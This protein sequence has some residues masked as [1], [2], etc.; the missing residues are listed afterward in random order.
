MPYFKRTWDEPRGDVHND[1]GTS[2]WYFETAADLWPT[3]QMEVYA[4]GTVL[5]YDTA[6]L[7][8]EYGGLSEAALEAEDF[9]PF[10][11]TQ[12]EFESAWNSHAPI[13]R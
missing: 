11:I 5:Q 1:W 12:T 9:A 10:A 6:H 3:R 7:N 2:V 4:N 8:D 13:N